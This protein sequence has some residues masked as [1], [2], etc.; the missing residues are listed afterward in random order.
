MTRNRNTGKI[1][2][3]LP[4]TVDQNVLKPQT[5]VLD[6]TVIPH[7]KIQITEIPQE[8]LPKTAL[9]QTPMSASFRYR[10]RQKSRIIT[11]TVAQTSHELTKGKNISPA[12]SKENFF[13]QFVLQIVDENKS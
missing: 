5:E 8:K 4:N 1:I 9:P 7:F 6:K 11:R 3:F 13:K 2:S 10:Y 12:S